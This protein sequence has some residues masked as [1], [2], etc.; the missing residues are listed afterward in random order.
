MPGNVF[1]TSAGQVPVI[2]TGQILDCPIAQSREASLIVAQRGEQ[3]NILQ[4]QT[5][6]VLGMQDFLC[7]NDV[8]HQ[9][10]RQ[11]V[12]QVRPV[13]AGKQ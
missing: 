7:R 8:L 1:R 6:R 13:A 4:I 2:P 10:I 11:P 3:R 5:A 12:W 9:S